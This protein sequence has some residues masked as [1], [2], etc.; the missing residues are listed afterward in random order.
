MILHGSTV[1][2]SVDGA[3]VT[4]TSFNAAV[5]DG[6]FG[7]LARDGSATFDTFRTRTNDTAFAGSAPWITVAD[8]SV[9]EGTGAN[10]NLT[11]TLNLS[12]PATAGMSVAW[13][14]APGTAT[15]ASTTPRPRARRSSPSAAR[16]RR[17]RSRSLATAAIEPNETFTVLLSNPVG[18]TFGDNAAVITIANDDAPAGVAVSAAATDSSGSEQ[19]P[20]PLVFTVSRTGSTAAALIV[21]LGWTGAAA[22]RRLHGRRVGRHPLGRP[23]DADDRRRRGD[24]DAHRDPGQRHRPRVHRVRHADRPRRCRLRTRRDGIRDRHDRRQR[25]RDLGRSNGRGGRRAGG[26][27]DRVHGHADRL[28]RGHRAR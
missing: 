9:S 3:L 21:N 7:V 22:V 8:T 14:T 28:P 4:S 20:D 11:L 10:G 2:V 5:V 12:A 1:S 27:H 25:R 6:A 23:R 17:S 19:G 15:P 26:Q 18:V 24:C 13:T 16:R